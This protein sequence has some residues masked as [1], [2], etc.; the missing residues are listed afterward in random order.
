MPSKKP[1]KKKSSTP[2]PQKKPDLIALLKKTGDLTCDNHEAIQGLFRLIKL[3]NK[4]L[5]LLKTRI[6][7]LEGN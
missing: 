1:L 4:Q 5:N 6:D 7:T 2:G 3:L